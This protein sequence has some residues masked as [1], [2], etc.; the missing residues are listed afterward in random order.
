MFASVV[1]SLGIILFPMHIRPAQFLI[2]AA[3]VAWD[4]ELTLVALQ[5]CGLNPAGILVR[6]CADK[7]DFTVPES[8]RASLGKLNRITFLTG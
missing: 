8:C 2:F 4:H 5:I 1:C 3:I 7:Y 6:R